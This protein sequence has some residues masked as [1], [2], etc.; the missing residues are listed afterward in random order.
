MAIGTL[1]LL[2]SGVLVTARTLFG[3]DTDEDINYGGIDFSEGDGAQE[4]VTVSSSQRGVVI[5][6]TA[7]QRCNRAR[8]LGGLLDSK[9]LDAYVRNP[10]PTCP[11]IFYRLK[12]FNGGKDPTGP[13]PATRWTKT[14]SAF[15]NVTS[16][17]IGGAAW[18][19][20][21]DRYQPGR[22]P[23][24]EGWI[25]TDSMVADAIGAQACFRVLDKPEPGCFV[26]A[27][28]GSGPRD[29]SIGHIGTVVEIP[30][31]IWSDSEAQWRAVVVVDIAAR[32]VG[33]RANKAT[34]A[35]GWYTRQA[36]WVVP[37]FP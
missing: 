35:Y 34:T 15:T 1:I 9:A 5:P 33:V 14:G 27:A 23:L 30:S 7:Q 18:C 16:D 6:L 13:D 19:G 37:A 24:Y 4:Q 29:G 21:F 10:K 28:S 26:V 17:C 2:G 3:N 31:G 11:D 25:N 36:R 12:D 22:F 20:G 8:Y 32:G